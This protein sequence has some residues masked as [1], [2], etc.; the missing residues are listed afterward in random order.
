MKD[1]DFDRLIICDIPVDSL[2]M[3]EVLELISAHIK[4]KRKTTIFTPNAD[5][6]VKARFDQELK[7]AYSEADL[8]LVDGMPLV[9]VSGIFGKRLPQR[10]NGTNLFLKLCETCSER[11]F[12][13]F[14]LGAREEV[15]GKA[16]NTIHKRFPSLKLSGSYTP[17]FEAVFEDDEVWKIAEQVNRARP[18]IVCV[19]FGCPKQEKWISRYRESLDATIFLT[20]GASLDFISGRL[21]RAP[22]WIQNAGLEWLWRLAQEPRRLWKRYL[23]GNTIFLYMIVKEIVKRKFSRAFSRS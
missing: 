4:T 14:L 19:A 22:E 15:T 20:I 8:S 16:V 6:V 23:I 17:P 10:I 7:K 2:T 18:D 9:W 13:M 21:R 5:H 11:G 3:D 12:S 1:A